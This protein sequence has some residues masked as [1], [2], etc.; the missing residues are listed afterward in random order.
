MSK[1]N[2]KGLS[3]IGIMVKDL[4]ASVDFY[5]RLGFVLDNEESIPARNVR[6]AFMSAG[7]CL[8]ELVERADYEPRPAGVVDHIALEVDD[9]DAAVASANEKGISINAAEINAANILGGIRNVFFVGPDGERLEFFEY[10]PK[11]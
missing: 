10:A 9:I 1:G 2:V 3:H 8:I 5:K 7:T 6:L 11:V 4:D